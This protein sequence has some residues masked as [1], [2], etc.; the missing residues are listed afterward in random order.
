MTRIQRDGDVVVLGL[1]PEERTILAS[2]AASLAEMLEPS[3]AAAADSDPLAVLVGISDG[4]IEKPDDPALRRLLPD[5]YADADG[6]A[7]FRRFTDA[8][9][10]AEKVANLRRILDG[11]TASGGVVRIGRDEVDGWLAGLNDIRLVLGERLDMTEEREHLEDLDADDPRV[12]LLAAY[13][14]LSEMQEWIVQLLLASA[15]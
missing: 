8:D 12:P 7:E 3:S 15:D 5:A 6:A 10:R 9:L 14:W 11:A 13:D 1:A 2:L 4:P